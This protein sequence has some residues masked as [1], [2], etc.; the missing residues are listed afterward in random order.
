[1]GGIIEYHHFVE[2]GLRGGKAATGEGAGK[3]VVTMLCRFVR[4]A[5]LGAVLLVIVIEFTAA[6]GSGGTGL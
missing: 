2:R 3:E 1:V 4:G 6:C 5:T